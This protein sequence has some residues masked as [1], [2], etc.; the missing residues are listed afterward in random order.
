MRISKQTTSVRAIRSPEAS[1]ALHNAAKKIVNAALEPA[2][3]VRH[4]EEAVPQSFSREDLLAARFRVSKVLP[5]QRSA[6]PFIG[7][8][9]LA[10]FS[11][12]LL[13]F[14]FPDWNF[15]SLGWVASAP[16]IMAVVREQR[17]WRSFFYGSIAG[18]IFYT[19]S[20]NWV[21]YSMHNYGGIP[22]WLCYVLLVI[23]AAALGVFTGL[24]SGVL[25][26]AVKHFGGWAILAAPTVWVASEFARN[27]VTGV[28]WNA[29]GYSQ[30]FQ[31]V[32]IQSARWGGVYAVSALMVATSAALVFALVY[33][34]RLRGFVVLS[35]A[36]VLVILAILYGSGTLPPNPATRS[37]PV[38][39]IQPNVPISVEPQ[40]PN[41]EEE[42]IAAHISLSEAAI[43]GNANGPNGTPDEGNDRA[44]VVIW[45]E[46]PMSFQYERDDKLRA[47][48]AEFT[49]RN[50]VFL[51]LNGWG[52]APG[53]DNHDGV[54]NSA[55]VIAPSGEK[56]SRYDKI[57][58]VPFGEYVPA[59]AVIPFM[60][61]IPALVADVT[62]GAN[63]TVVEAGRTRLGATICFETIRPDIARQMRR[64][65]ASA[66]VQ[67]SNEGWF[68]PTAAARQMLAHAVFRA[69]ENN[70]EL[71]RATNSGL[72]A[73]ISANGFVGGETGLFERATRRWRISA[74]DEVG[75][76]TFY[77][78]YGDVLAVACVAAS[79]LLALGALATGIRKGKGSED[80]RGI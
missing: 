56:I 30:A 36:G 9:S 13:V 47:R 70:V 64:Q 18:T 43:K 59:R 69:V 31:P 79:T 66:L 48:L 61:R 77:T 25:A 65:G 19:G 6:K 37:V 38:A 4:R 51:L 22:Q 7:N 42:L 3:R 40:N 41:V 15:W 35:A 11:G 34:E 28:G 23:L 45:P 49:R 10:I 32:V 39:V 1:R 26:F 63:V 76:I 54:C 80:D 62:P 73:E 57:A 71:I 72:S 2:L 53:T 33:L 75:G 44:E 68:G 55:I 5:Y 46:S 17:F 20:S 12:L 16:L 67:L 52:A 27:E 24:F 29:L 21:T 8:L 74:A 60:D 50:Q 14:A 78:A 58:L